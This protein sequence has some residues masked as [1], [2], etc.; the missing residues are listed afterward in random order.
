[1]YWLR[2]NFIANMPG[3]QF[4]LLYAGVI[5]FVLVLCWARLHLSD[6]AATLPAPLV[7]NQ[8]DPYAIAY[9]RGGATEV[10]RLLVFALLEGGLLQVI[11]E[12]KKKWRNPKPP[13]IRRVPEVNNLSHL[14]AMERHALGWFDRP[15]TGTVT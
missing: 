14:S 15:R 1:M 7:P 13:H 10:A 3:P 4:L 11:E 5:G 9:L 2:H 6:S 8:P 12:P